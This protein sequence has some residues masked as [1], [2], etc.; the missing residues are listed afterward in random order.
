M[1]TG[2]A[3]GIGAATA[4]LAAQ[5]G[6]RVVVADIDAQA[7]KLV[8]DSLG[9]DAIA[10]ELDIRDEHAWAAAFDTAEAALGP[11]EVLVNNAGII[12]TGHATSLT[13]AQHRH[14][15]EVNLLGTITGVLTAL[16][17][18]N[19][20]GAGH[21]VE[22]CSMT[23][24]L[25]LSGYATYGATKHA[26]RAFHHSVALEQ[27]QGPVTFSIVHPPSTRTPMLEQEMADPS[28]VIAFAERSHSAQ[29]IAAAVLRAIERKS[30]EVVFPPL[31]G[32]VQRLFGSLPSLMY[33]V[34]PLVEASGRRRRARVTRRGAA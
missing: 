32:R 2:A 12:H 7:A 19:A 8:A 20:R 11:V 27:R 31:A 13:L 17:R 15:V 9:A 3:S 24:F 1:I 21:I 26:I 34:I 22:V 18:M 30:A 10:C 5:R 28:A 4:R 33:R 23:S 25:P 16:E 29:S 6:Y 14:M